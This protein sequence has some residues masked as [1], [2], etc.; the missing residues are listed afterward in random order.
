M[1]LRDTDSPHISW[2]CPWQTDS[3]HISSRWPWETLTH[4][5]FHQDVPERD[6]L[7]TYF[8]KMSLRLR[9]TDWPHISSICPWERLTHHIFNQDDL[10]RH[11]LTT[12][13]M[14]MSLRDSDSPH[15]SWRWPWETLTHHIFHEDVPDL[16][17]E[18]VGGG[19]H[20]QWV[21]P[22]LWEA[23]WGNVTMQCAIDYCQQLEVQLYVRV[24]CVML[25][26]SGNLS[27]YIC[28]Y[29]CFC[30]VAVLRVTLLN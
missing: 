5:I 9:E 15:I 7:T 2:R 13:F 29:L 23:T 26:F 18:G 6:W 14:Q 3:P 25:Y 28:M 21:H 19:D 1:T 11:R 8:I 17:G 20:F 24:L 27:Y 30:H 12:Y 16:S 10:E 4:H 22:I